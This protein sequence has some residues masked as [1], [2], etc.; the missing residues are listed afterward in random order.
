MNDKLKNKK[1]ISKT[2][3]KRSLKKTKSKKEKPNKD[4]SSYLNRTLRKSTIKK[5]LEARR[6][7]FCASNIK[8]FEREYDEMLKHRKGRKKSATIQKEMKMILR[9]KT[10][11]KQI[12][13]NNDFYTFINYEWLKN[14]THMQDEYKNERYIV[15]YDDFRIVQNKVYYDLIEI[16]ENYIKENPHTQKAKQLSN[17]Y[18]A[19]LRLLDDQQARF[20]LNKYV[21]FL[22]KCR[23][24]KKESDAWYFLGIM[25]KN[26]IIS[27]GLPFVFSLNPDEKEPEIA[28][29]YIS[30]PQYSLLD[31]NVYINDGEDVSYKENYRRQFYHYIDEMFTAFYGKNHGYNP[32]DVYDCELE[33]LNSII[34]E[35]EKDETYSKVTRKEAEEKY[36]F[37]WTTMAR[38]LGFHKPPDFFI[39][40]NINYLRC[41]TKM[42]LEGWHTEKWRTYYVYIYMRQLIR[43]HKKWRDISYRFLGRFMRG[44]ED[45]F[46]ENLLCIFN[47]A[48]SFNTFLTNEYIEKYANVAAIDYLK[49]MAEDL[50]IVYKRTIQRNTW[51]QPKTKREALLKLD[52]FDIE[53]GSP[54]LLREDPLLDYCDT[55]LWENLN[56]INRWRM[57]SAVKLEGKLNID[58]P[59]IDWMEQPIKITGSQSYVVNAYYTST[60]NKIYIPIAYIQKP[61]I[62][63]EERGIEYN[64]A[65][66]GFT[67]GHEMS[68]SLDD[69]GSQYDYRGR[70]HNWWTPQDTKIF[71]RKQND[72][73]KQYEE[74]ARRDG[75]DYDASISIGE[76]LADIS[77]LAICLEYLKDFL[78][79]NNAVIPIRVLS[80]KAFMIYYAFQFKQ[81]IRKRAIKAQIRTNPHPLDKY[82]TNIPLSRIQIFR[83]LYN[84]KE[85]DGMW[86]HNFD[87]IW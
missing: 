10:V 62:D 45:L 83:D 55:D 87:T 33:I 8:P 48:F 34:C 23:Q 14:A 53:I 36:G 84:V 4:Y 54:K 66:I 11:P 3:K 82:R 18:K 7:K 15:Q 51:M 29:S 6:S 78:D 68:H 9:K 86:W 1:K 52:H 32:K 73:I 21:A 38:G 79:K 69:L 40:N 2:Q 13:P 20:H 25:N 59:V 12:L 22:D 35:K 64:L 49:V 56:K 44:Q 67:I 60:Q 63:L 61:F 19:G 17:V 81:K 57:L 39:V 74:F 41:G 27:P 46:P 71:Q 28:R 80:F 75:I 50:K 58:I 24:S 43:F 30:Q 70:L 72:V 77:G 16:V 26:E 47:L 85:G 42:F 76:D 5:F 37:D 31:F 65:T